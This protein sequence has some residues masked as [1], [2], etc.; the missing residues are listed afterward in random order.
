MPLK[1]ASFNSVAGTLQ[2][3]PASRTGLAMALLLTACSPDIPVVDQ[4]VSPRDSG[5]HN[6][7]DSDTNRADDSTGNPDTAAGLPATETIRSALVEPLF[8]P[9]GG[10]FVGS[11]TVTISASQPGGQVYACKAMP[12]STCKLEPYKVPLALHAS[13][14]VHARV[15]LPGTLGEE[16][17]RSYISIDPS[18]Q[19]FSSDIPLLVFWTD[20]TAP[21]SS[22]RVPMGLD[23][24]EPSPH[25]TSLLD[26][27][28]H[29]GRC[30]LKV[31]GSSS[32]S[33]AKRPYD[34]ELWQADSEE[35]RKEVMLGMPAEADWVLYAPY[36][37]DEALIRNA[38]GYELS[39]NIGRY[40]PRTAFAELFVAEGG[41]PVS[42]SDYVGVYSL[43]EEIEQGENRVDVSE[44]QP[45]DVSWPEISGGYV[46][47]RDRTGSGESG[48]YV[49]TA[50]GA[51]SFSYPL[52]AVDPE[53]DELADE[54]SDYLCEEIDDMAWALAADDFTSPYTGRHYTQILDRDSWIDHN[55]L[56]ILVKNPDAFRLSGYMSKDR[57]GPISAGPLWDLD[58]TMGAND[59]RATDPT[60]WDA[61]NLT[62]DT[63]EAFTWGWYSRMFDDPVFR[64]A[65]WARW[66]ELLD[67]E[68]SEES[69]LAVVDR[70]ADELDESA[71]RNYTRW[72]AYS[73]G[74]D[75]EIENLRTWLSQRVAWIAACIDS[76]EDPRTCTGD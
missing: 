52:V 70:M 36:Y 75:T 59:Y 37:Y 71:D 13:T 34:L 56:N 33:Q 25:R 28:S 53:E 39:N 44:I 30:G 31:R 72:S 26:I 18:L 65:Y 38:L 49:G 47:K 51:F 55:I 76:L 73:D 40:A 67:G 29:S 58:R 43:V 32:V 41:A 4:L 14:I 21:T 20:L 57:G 22:T 63:T 6:T 12:A 5:A 3:F 62:S 24:F 11:V 54:Q 17:A 10:G 42:M 16:R 74:F 68:L 2:L 64:D 27:P 69:I 19:D 60:Y 45:D 66:T 35:D 61:S 1:T 46:F 50:G 48:F 8:D 15:D 9:P 23:V 7:E